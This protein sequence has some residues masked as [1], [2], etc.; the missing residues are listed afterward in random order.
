MPY[1]SLSDLISLEGNLQTSCQFWGT[2]LS[3]E[4]L[5]AGDHSFRYTTVRAVVPVE[6][7]RDSA[8]LSLRNPCLALHFAFHDFVRTA[9]C[10]FQTSKTYE[11]ARAFDEPN[12]SFE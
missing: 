12:Q 4:I 1:C 3:F 10:A 8:K 11:S 6:N 7:I 5:T 9:F 2:F